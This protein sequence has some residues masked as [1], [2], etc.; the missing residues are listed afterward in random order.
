[1]VLYHL[2]LTYQLKELEL[3]QRQVCF[4]V[5]YKNISSIHMR[6]TFWSSE[7]L[8]ATQRIIMRLIRQYVDIFGKF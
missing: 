7:T 6:R 4:D 8:N 1:M 3:Q 2:Q 5:A